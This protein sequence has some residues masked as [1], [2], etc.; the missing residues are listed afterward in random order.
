MNKN[1]AKMYDKTLYEAAGFRVNSKYAVDLYGS[2]NSYM[3]RV[4]DIQKVLEVQDL[5]EFS[6]RY[7]WVNLPRGISSDI[8]ERIL[9]YRGRAVFYYNDA[10]EKFQFLPF[11]PNNVIDEYGR[12]THCNTFPFTGVSEN[13]GKKKYTKMGIEVVY[14]DLFLQDD[15]FNPDEINRIIKEWET[16]S[17]KGIILNDSILGLSQQPIIR[18]NI[19]KPMIGSMTTCYQIINTAMFASADYNLIK[20]STQD[21]L[22]SLKGQIATINREI[23]NGNR[24]GAI[25][26]DINLDSLRTTNASSIQDLFETFNSLDNYRKSTMGVDNAGVFNKKERMLQQEQALNGSNADSIYSDGLYQRQRFCDLVNQYYGT[27]IWCL[28]KNMPTPGE[29]MNGSGESYSGDEQ[30]EEGGQNV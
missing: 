30:V 29:M 20:V 8:I 13:K 23:L 4:E 5:R 28:S 14:D 12:W 17:D 10:V 2:S 3:T 7:Q 11:A 25:M 26:G 18:S 19:S 24:F 16:G 27:N 6:E 21:D 15:L 22:N 9:Y 1:K